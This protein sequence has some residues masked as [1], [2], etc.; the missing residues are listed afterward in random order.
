MT[1]TSSVP[2]VTATAGD[3]ATFEYVLKVT[4]QYTKPPIWRRIVVPDNFTFNLLHKTIQVAMG[5][6]N[7]HLHEFFDGKRGKNYKGKTLI[8]KFFQAELKK[9]LTYTYDLGDSWRHVVLLEKVNPFDPAKSYPQCIGGKLACPPED[10][11]GVVSFE[12]LVGGLKKW[13]AG[14]A[15]NPEAEQDPESKDEYTECGW[16]EKYIQRYLDFQPEH[17]NA[18][19]VNFTNF[20]LLNDCEFNPSACGA[21][22]LDE[23]S[24]EGDLW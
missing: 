23:D 1:T 9:K 2:T 18:K 16:G 5:W 15:G 22:E 24:E 7:A 12:M 17:F 4:L 10:C 21:P 6:E 8:S 19:E 3:A 20:H 14:N 11:G 13:R